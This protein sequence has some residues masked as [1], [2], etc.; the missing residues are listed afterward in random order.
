LKSGFDFGGPSKIKEAAKRNHPPKGMVSTHSWR[1]PK[2][3][4]LE[5]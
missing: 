5:K 3:S 4:R 1:K 2:G